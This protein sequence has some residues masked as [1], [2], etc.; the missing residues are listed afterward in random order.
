MRKR[1]LHNLLVVGI[2]LSLGFGVFGTPG[3]STE[4]KGDGGIRIGQEAPDFTLKAP[5]RKTEY[6]LHEL[7]GHYV[8]IEFW[9]S[10][11][12]PCRKES[13]NLVRAYEK[14]KDADLDNGDGFR[15]LSVSL[16]K[17]EKDWKKAIEADGL[18]WPHHVSEL[19]GWKGK[20]AQ[21]YNVRQIPKNFLV[22]PEGKVIAKDLRGRTL[23]LRMDEYVRS[24]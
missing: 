22:N 11:C 17:S 14:Y 1:S 20:A 18:D 4:K 13:P 6:S 19:K 10:W 12:Q 2:L 21:K 15:I 24:F 7:R 3:G 23:H 16:D 5:D 8:L 9:A